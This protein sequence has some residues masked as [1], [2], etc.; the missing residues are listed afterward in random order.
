[1][2]QHLPNFKHL[3]DLLKSAPALASVSC[4]QDLK[5]LAMQY[6]ATNMDF[7]VAALAEL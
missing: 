1:M 3:M 4:S 5:L 6:L 7:T 2:L